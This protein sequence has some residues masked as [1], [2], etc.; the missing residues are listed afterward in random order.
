MGLHVSAVLAAALLSLGLGLASAGGNLVS[1]N[2]KSTCETLPA[3]IHITK[4]NKKG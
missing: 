1:R 3:E 4:G 2:Y